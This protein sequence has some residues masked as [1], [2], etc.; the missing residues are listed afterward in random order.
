MGKRTIN[1]L[2]S[3]GF[4]SE[5]AQRLDHEEHTLNSLKG[6]S[7]DELRGLNFTD[8]QIKVIFNESRPPIPQRILIKVLYESRWTCCICR[9]STQGVIVHHINE[10]C[11]SR[12]HEEE[13]LVVLC[14]NHHG[15]AHTKRDL[16]LNLNPDKLK[17]TKELWLETIRQQD[18]QVVLGKSPTSLSSTWDYFNHSR[19]IDISQKLSIKASTLNNYSIL[20]K[21]NQINSDGSPA[22]ANS[23]AKYMYDFLITS[24]DPYFFYSDLTEKLLEKIQWIKLY[25]EEW[26]HSFINSKVKENTIVICKGLFDFK[27]LDCGHSSGLHQM[28]SGLKRGGDIQ[29]NFQFNAYESTSSSAYFSHL[30]QKSIVTVVCLIRSK[31]RSGKK[32]I[33]NSSV[34]AI[35]N[36][37]GPPHIGKPY[38]GSLSDREDEYDDDFRSR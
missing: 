19:L 25:D 27:E 28:R 24:R 3:R 17:G 4:D 33:L 29:L 5:T 23:E 13:N 7:S 1:A 8:Q 30:C 10:Y 18:S 11:E 22:W 9:D 36:G 15:E 26:N 21:G 38:G 37:F 35:G 32:I 20:L 34:L 16:Q 12:S 6:M 2:M 31:S 14:L